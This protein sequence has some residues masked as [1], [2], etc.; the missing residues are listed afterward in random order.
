MCE[1]PE[2]ARSSLRNR[3]PVRR[4]AESEIEGRGHGPPRGGKMD[5]GLGRVF[6]YGV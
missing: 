2:A 3:S 6:L 5:S 4:G 1:G